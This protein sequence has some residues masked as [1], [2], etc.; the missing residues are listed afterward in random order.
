M[1]VEVVV[2]CASRHG[3]VN[4]QERLAGWVRFMDVSYAHLPNLILGSLILGHEGRVGQQCLAR[5]ISFVGGLLTCCLA[6]Q[7]PGERT[8]ECSVEMVPNPDRD[9]SLRTTN[10][11]MGRTI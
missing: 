4:L 5:S 1:G 10:I 9:W 7:Q 3:H 6:G 8:I 2:P 11:E